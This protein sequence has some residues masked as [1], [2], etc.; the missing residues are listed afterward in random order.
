MLQ[1]YH[2]E[3]RRV[4]PQMTTELLDRFS[5]RKAYELFSDVKP[6]FD[7]LKKRGIRTNILSN[8]DDKALLALQELGLGKYMIDD[9]CWSGLTAMEEKENDRIGTMY[10]SPR[11]CTISY[12]EGFEKPDKRIF[13]AALLRNGIGVGDVGKKEV[14]YVGDQVDEDFWGAR[15]AGLHALWLDRGGES[16]QPAKGDETDKERGTRGVVAV[17]ENR[18]SSLSEV[19]ERIANGE[20]EGRI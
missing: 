1:Q 4:L 13:E 16:N 2:N 19:L 18:I 14:L 10:F 20:T 5:G 11:G 12:F 17:K 9:L 3:L 6:T 8:S 15:D 7:E